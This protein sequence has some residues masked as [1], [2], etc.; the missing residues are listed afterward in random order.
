MTFVFIAIYDLFK[1]V[2]KYIKILKQDKQIS[3][4][5]LAPQ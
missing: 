1:L 2:Y 3:L 5:F 4:K